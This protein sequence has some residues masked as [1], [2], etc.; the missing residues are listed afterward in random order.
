MSTAELIAYYTNLLIMQYHGLPKAQATIAALTAPVIMDQLPQQVND[1]FNIN[2]AVG[3]QLDIIGKY[4]GVTRQAN[5]QS[6]PVILNDSDF[7]KLIQIAIVENNSHGSLSEIQNLLYQF[8]NGGITVTDNQNMR[9]EYTIQ[10]SA[11][12]STLAEVFINDG[13]LPHPM[14]VGVGIAYITFPFPF[15]FRTYYAAAPVNSSPFN[16]YTDF[17]LN[18]TWVSYSDIIS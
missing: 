14:G 11:V 12:S 17:N 13:L 18:W 9:L 10:Q 8:F 16:N 2:T 4:E 3:V 6:G 15:S 1:A 5:T 7:A